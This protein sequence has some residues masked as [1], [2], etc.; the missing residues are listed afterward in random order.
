LFWIEIYEDSLFHHWGGCF[1]SGH[2]IIVIGASAGGVEALVQLVREFPANLPASVFV[3]LHIPAQGPSFLADILTRSGLVKAVQPIDYEPI[4]RG[5]IYVAPPDHHLLLEDGLMRIVRGPKENRHRPAIDPLF[6]SAAVAYGPQVVGVVLTGSLDDG[7]A[8][9]LAIKQRGGIAVVQDPHDAIY[10]SMPES[11]LAHVKVDHCLPM[12]QIGQLLMELVREEV[13]QKDI[14]S[15]S[16]DMKREVRITAMETNPL[17]EN[18]QV[19]NPSAYSCPECGGVLWETSDGELT[20]YRCRTGHA[21]STE[22]VLAQQTEQIEQALGVALKT[23]DENASLSRRMAKQAQLNGHTWLAEQLNAKVQVAEQ[24]ATLLRQVLT[25]RD[26]I[27]LK[28]TH[29][30]S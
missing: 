13:V 10:S 20:R 27:G 22:S 8:G 23:L 28:D 25:G 4:E 9:L 3:V 17:N 18:E 12:A 14:Q 5:H 16:E 15:A 1:V 24:R 7:T 11:A 2:E 29:S 21:F 30:A 6:R 26:A 19:G